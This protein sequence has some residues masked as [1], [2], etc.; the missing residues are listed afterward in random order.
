M[1][2]GH[3][4]KKEGVPRTEWMQIRSEQAGEKAT[5]APRTIPRD[6]GCCVIH[7]APGSQE[8]TT[9][10]KKGGAPARA[11]AGAPSSR[12]RD[13][14]VGKKVSLCESRTNENK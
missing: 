4:G 14:H 8:L 9:A 10:K 12:P 5:H 13:P 6:E 3:R 1:G 7:S 2:V 11:G